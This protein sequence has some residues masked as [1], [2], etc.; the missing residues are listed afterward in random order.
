[1]HLEPDHRLPGHQRTS[2]SAPDDPLQRRGG[3]EQ[4]LVLEERGDEL[5]ADRQP[6]APPDRQAQRRKAREIHGADEDVGEVHRHRI[7][8]LLARLER[9]ASAWSG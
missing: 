1:M 9:R 3:G 8:G 6:L 2:A 5:G 4:P 7:V